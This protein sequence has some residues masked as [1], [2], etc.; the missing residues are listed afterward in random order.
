MAVEVTWAALAVVIS[1]LTHAIFT[2]WSAATFK[3]TISIKIDNL[4]SA[5][6]R[7]DRELEKRDTQIAAAWRKIDDIGSRV[8]KIETVCELRR[9]TEGE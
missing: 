1:V 4:V 8:S 3:A 2:V 9:E 5:L 6:Q 7:L